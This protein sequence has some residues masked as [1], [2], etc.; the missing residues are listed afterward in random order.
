MHASAESSSKRCIYC[1][2]DCSNKPRLKD[3]MGRYSCREC[4]DRKQAPIPMDDGLPVDLA[5][6][7]SAAT[8]AGGLQLCPGCQSSMPHGSSVCVQCGFDTRKGAAITTAQGVDK[9]RSGG[10]GKCPECGYSLKGLRENRCPECGT[11]IARMTERERAREDSAR[12]ARMAYVKP[13]IQLAVGIA[14]MA[15]LLLGRERGDEMVYFATLYGSRL[16][17]VLLVHV[18]CCVIWIGF[19]APIRLIV[20]RMAG[21]LALVD[22]L[23]LFLLTFAP[24]PLVINVIALLVLMA[25]LADSFEIELV[26]AVIVGLIAYLARIL[27]T[28][29]VNEFAR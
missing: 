13:L 19:D 21:V 22:M 5:G 12:I 29:A 8:P 4:V 20:L 24:I 14:A 23:A 7:E 28:V 25:L 15:L 10:K 17:A 9:I 27:A 26:D 3:R 18:T 16:A 11:I 1:G 2:Q 6:M